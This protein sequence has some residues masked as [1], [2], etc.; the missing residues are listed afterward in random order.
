MLTEALK[1]DFAAQNEKH[2]LWFSTSFKKQ[3]AFFERFKRTKRQNSW[4]KQRF[5]GRAEFNLFIIHMI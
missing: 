5:K 4:G 2:P 3:G 1:S